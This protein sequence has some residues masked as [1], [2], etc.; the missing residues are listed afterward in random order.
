MPQM[1][2]TG[3]HGPEDPSRAAL[4]FHLARGAKEAG[5][6]VAVALAVDATMLVKDV[7][8]DNIVPV[9]MPS[10]KELF[11]FAVDNKIPIYV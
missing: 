6:D 3:T 4:P 10:L 2:F 9:G 11:Q 8:K 1:L 5:Y 7:I